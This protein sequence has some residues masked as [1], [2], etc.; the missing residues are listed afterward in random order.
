MKVTT[1]KYKQMLVKPGFIIEEDFNRALDK[2][3]RESK[4]LPEVLIEDGLIEDKQLGRL[5]ATEFNY[6]FI[7]LREEPV[8]EEVIRIVPELVA[9]MQQVIVFDKTKEGLKVAMADPENFEMIDW[10]ER[11]T[12]EKVISYYATPLDIKRALKHYRKE[13]E[14]TFEEIIESQVKIAEKGEIKAEDVPI[15][16]ILDT[17]IE[18]AYENRVSDIHIEPLKSVAQVRFRIDGILHNV[19]T[20][21][22]NIYTLIITRVKVLARLRTDEHFAAQDGKFTGEFEGER[23]DIRVSIVPVTEGENIVLRLLSERARRFNLESLGLPESDLEKVSNGIKKSYGMILTTGPTGCGKTTTLYSILKILNRPEINICTIEDPVEYDI[24]GV[25]QIQVNTKTNLTFAKGLRSIVRQDPDIIMV[26]EIRDN[27]TAD[28]AVNS[29]MTGHLVLSTM[30]A[31]TAATNLI[32]LI[33]MG[34][35]PFLVASSVNLVVA[36]R[37]VRQICMKCRES[38]EVTISDLENM[39]LSKKNIEYL[40]GGKKKTRLYHGKGCKSCVFTGYSGRIGIFEVMEMRDDIRDLV[41]R[42][43][44]ADDIQKQAIQDGMTTIMDDGI[45]KAL[46][47]ITTLEEV[48]RV[49]RE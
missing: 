44:N 43:V 23:F 29:A 15:I 4:S 1:E 47:G 46:S 17:L 11:K 3:Q 32:R 45:N 30:H 27:E 41:M 33:D 42:K 16:K 12:G 20:L 26:G 8:S 5:I 10:L 35:E 31:N 18:Y 14:R 13:L 49:T 38:Y 22:K 37:L 7:D 6:K 34:I 19:L 9:K 40:M 39:Q 24:Q 36:Q 25:S 48:I 2:A 28:I 21:P